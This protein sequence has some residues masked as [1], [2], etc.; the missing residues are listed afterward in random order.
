MPT[1]IGEVDVEKDARPGSHHEGWDQALDRALDQA[2][3]FGGQ[4]VK[5]E[6]FALLTANPG[7]IQRY[8]VTIS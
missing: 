2:G 4:Y 7:Q 1:I 3:A 6:F 8:I 5:I